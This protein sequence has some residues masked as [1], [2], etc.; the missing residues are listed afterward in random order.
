M[1]RT[2]SNSRRW[3][4]AEC[5]KSL[6]RGPNRLREIFKSKFRRRSHENEICEDKSISSSLYVGKLAEHVN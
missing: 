6:Q 3:D 5:I 2:R 1:E 4:G